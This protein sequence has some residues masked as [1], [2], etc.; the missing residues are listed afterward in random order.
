MAC[1]S[2]IAAAGVVYFRDEVIVRVC[3]RLHLTLD[4]VW[5]TFPGCQ[6]TLRGEARVDRRDFIKTGVSGLGGFYVLNTVEEILAKTEVGSSPQLG[7]APRHV[8]SL[9]RN[10]LYGGRHVPGADGVD[11]DDS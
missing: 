10:W 7:P 5:Y 6:E 3:K 4:Q 1:A 8:L 11:F 2:R 9:N